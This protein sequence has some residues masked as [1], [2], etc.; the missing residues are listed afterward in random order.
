MWALFTR[1]LNRFFNFVQCTQ[2]A[3]ENKSFYLTVPKL[4]TCVSYAKKKFYEIVSQIFVAFQKLKIFQ[5]E[6][7]DSSEFVEVAKMT[8]SN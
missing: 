1:T 6:N 4:I 2:G 8:G 5:Q 3:Q 7:S